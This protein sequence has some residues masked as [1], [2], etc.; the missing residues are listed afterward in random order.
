MF[1]FFFFF[2]RLVQTFIVVLSCCGFVTFGECAKLLKKPKVYNAIITTDEE[3]G[4]SRAYPIIQNGIP[5]IP[6]SISN[7]NDVFDEPK[8][9]VNQPKLAL[10]IDIV[11]TLLIHSVTTLTEV[12]L[13]NRLRVTTTIS[14]R[15][16]NIC[17]LSFPFRECRT[18]I[19]HIH[20]STTHLETSKPFHNFPFYRRLSIQLK[21]RNFRQSSSHCFKLARDDST[22]QIGLMC[23]N[24]SIRSEVMLR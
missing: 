4:P 6:F 2:F 7:R 5:I 9:S 23:W 10:H 21:I 12:R 14:R 20:S 22:I 13:A 19:S 18:I 16:W 11:T 17:H 3:L 1:W 15:P 8:N 24:L